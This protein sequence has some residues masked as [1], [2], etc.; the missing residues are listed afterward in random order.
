MRSVPSLRSRAPEQ[1]WKWRF[2]RLGGAN[3]L[4]PEIERNLALLG[5]IFPAP[6]RP[7]A[8]LPGAGG[9]RLCRQGRCESRPDTEACSFENGAPGKRQI[10]RQRTVGHGILLRRIGVRPLAVSSQLQTR[11]YQTAEA[12]GRWPSGDQVS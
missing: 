3:A 10:G 11:S 12:A 8:R 5:P 9:L 1:N 4:A 6:D 2:A 7:F